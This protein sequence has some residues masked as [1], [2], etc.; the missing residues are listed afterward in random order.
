MRE[1]TQTRL[2]NLVEDV[3]VRRRGEG[4][5]DAYLRLLGE[6][7]DRLW[8]QYRRSEVKVD[9]GSDLTVDA[10]R[11]HFLPHYA[12][13]TFYALDGLEVLRRIPREGL[14]VAC[15]ASG[16]LPEI[17]GLAEAA[18]AGGIDRGAIRCTAYDACPS[19]S[20]AARDSVQIARELAPN[21][22]IEIA[23]RTVDLMAEAPHLPEYDLVVFQNCLNE[24]C[25]FG[26]PTECALAFCTRV[27]RGGNVVIIDQN[28]YEGNVQ[29]ITTWRN[30]LTD[31]HGFQ[32]RS[33]FD[34]SMEKR[35]E[36]RPPN[37]TFYEFYGAKRKPEG[38]WEVKRQP[39]KGFRF[40]WEILSRV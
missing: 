19:W 35:W 17:I 25:H 14:D 20:P 4:T 21:I 8:G 22:T 15:V 18:I 24:V 37:R 28:R 39:R 2:Y 32:V 3:V 7:F 13:M 6:E 40:S 29:T 12:L 10:Y 5:P 33:R 36:M 31:Q 16:P 9:Y 34:P 11:L 38:G 27:R 23:E 30:V 1:N 26:Q